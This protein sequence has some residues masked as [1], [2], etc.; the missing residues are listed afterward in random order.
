MIKIK[1]KIKIIINS[2]NKKLFLKNN[3]K[4]LSNFTLFLNKAINSF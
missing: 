1:I 3:N 2:H 4:I